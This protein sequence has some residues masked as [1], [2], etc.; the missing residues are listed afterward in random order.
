[1]KLVILL[2]NKTSCKK[3]FSKTSKKSIVAAVTFFGVIVALMSDLSSLPDKFGA[4]DN[5]VNDEEI[6]H[7]IWY[8]DYTVDQP[9]DS[10]VAHI[11]QTG[12]TEFFE[13]GKFSYVGKAF[14][15]INDKDSIMNMEM[16]IRVAGEWY[17]NEKSLVWTVIGNNM[18]PISASLN[19]V[20]LDEIDANWRKNSLFQS[21]NIITQGATTKYDILEKDKDRIRVKSMQNTGEFVEFNLERRTH[22]MNTLVSK[23][24]FFAL[25]ETKVTK[26]DQRPNQTIRDRIRLAKAESSQYKIPNSAQVIAKFLTYPMFNRFNESPVANNPYSTHAFVSTVSPFKTLNSD[27]VF[28]GGDCRLGIE[29]TSINTSIS[30][31]KLEVKGISCTDNR[32]VAYS[33]DDDGYIGY[34]SELNAPGIASIDIVDDDGMQ[35]IDV[36]KNYVVQ[37]YSP[38]NTLSKKGLSF[39]GRF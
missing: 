21:R 7:G 6:F 19:D 34:V 39:F 24:T 31:V 8:T 13:N 14:T 22:H 16:E 15:T 1:M 36:K 17:A 27:L 25:P 29:A 18:S 37:F 3:W 32:G 26:H 30:K 33:M 20:N 5:S 2:M 23:D 9:I 4:L 11:R 12:T 35:T 28:D 10:R 38:I